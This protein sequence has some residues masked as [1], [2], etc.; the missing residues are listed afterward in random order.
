MTITNGEPYLESSFLNTCQIL[1]GDLGVLKHSF[2]TL[3][4]HDRRRARGRIS[5]CWF[6]QKPHKCAY[7]NLSDALS[8]DAEFLLQTRGQNSSTINA[9]FHDRCR[10]RVH[11]VYLP[12]TTSWM[13][14]ERNTSWL[15][16]CFRVKFWNTWKGVSLPYWKLIAILKSQQVP[17]ITLFKIDFGFFGQRPVNKLSSGSDTWAYNKR[18]IVLTE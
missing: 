6:W 14:T 10:F 15:T 18:Y 12:P 17:L 2:P 8:Y 11:A 13:E 16:W 9:P 4:L 5:H 3:S 7:A 1:R